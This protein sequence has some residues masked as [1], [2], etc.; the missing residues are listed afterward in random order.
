MAARGIYVVY[1][2][3]NPFVEE[4]GCTPDTAMPQWWHFGGDP[5]CAYLTREQSL[6]RRR[7]YH[8]ALLRISEAHG[9]FAVLDLFDVF[10]PGRVCKFYNPDGV[11][12]YRDMWSH[13]SAEA[14]VLAKPV[15][16][17]T[18]DRLAGGASP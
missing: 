10:C 3:G 15:L 17:E 5:P 11:F 2:A 8:A 1:Q 16:L 14:S 7:A 4:S 13:P 9:N 12:L 18:V 6:E